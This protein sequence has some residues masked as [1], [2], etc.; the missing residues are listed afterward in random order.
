MAVVAQAAAAAWSSR[1]RHR[2][3]IRIT[4]HSGRITLSYVGESLGQPCS[5]P[6]ALTLLTRVVACEGVLWRD[7]IRRR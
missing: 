2:Q 4:A 6:N 3:Y 1:L 5:I 7:R